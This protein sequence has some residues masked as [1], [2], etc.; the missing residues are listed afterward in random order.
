VNIESFVGF[1][2][3]KLDAGLHS[4]I[5]STFMFQTNTVEV[6]FIRYPAVRIKPEYSIEYSGLIRCLGNANLC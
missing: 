1:P 5:L 3:P 2:S 4:A 6:Q